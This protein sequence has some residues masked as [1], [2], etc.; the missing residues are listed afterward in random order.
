MRWRVLERS[1][2]SVRGDPAVVTVG[3]DPHVARAR[4]GAAARHRR[5]AQP[6]A[7]LNLP[8]RHGAVTPTRFFHEPGP[9]IASVNEEIVD[10]DARLAGE[11]WT[12]R[13]AE[14]SFRPTTAGSPSATAQASHQRHVAGHLPGRSVG[15]LRGFRCRRRVTD[16]SQGGWC[17]GGSCGRL[18]DGRGRLT[19]AKRRRQG[20]VVCRA[21][22]PFEGL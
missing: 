21:A 4:P 6:A 15:R 18:R 8:A 19:E 3:E 10:L 2:R 7:P 20:L 16:V 17:G 22:L 14:C 12:R 11:H 9:T 1:A 13:R 5:A